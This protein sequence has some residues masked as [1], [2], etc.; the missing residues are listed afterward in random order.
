M[1]IHWAILRH[2]DFVKEKRLDLLKDLL[3]EKRLDLQ[4]DLQMVRH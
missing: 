3:M 2:L 1:E 4:M